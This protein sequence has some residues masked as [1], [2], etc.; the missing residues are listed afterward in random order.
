MA[1]I[2]AAIIIAVSILIAFRWEI[3]SPGIMRLDRWTGTIVLCDVG[4]D[5]PAKANCEPK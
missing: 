4:N 5:R 3:A 1:I 2:G